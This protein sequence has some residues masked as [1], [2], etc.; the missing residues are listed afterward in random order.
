M[1]RDGDKVPQGVTS[2]S[3][4]EE[5]KGKG[6]FKINEGGKYKVEG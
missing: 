3:G 6:V 1:E 2:I 5:Y 4:I